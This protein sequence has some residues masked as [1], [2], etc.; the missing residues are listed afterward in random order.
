L[1]RRTASFAGPW[2]AKAERT[3]V[4]GGGGQSPQRSTSETDGRPHRR[5]HGGRSGTSARVQSSQNGHEPF[6]QPA[7]PRGNRTSTAR[8]SAFP[9]TRARYG[10]PPTPLRGA[11]PP[12]G[13]RP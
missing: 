13:R 2:Y 3:D 11:R 7:Q 1:S 12:P 9:G 8:S 6:P 4:M 10:A 5:H